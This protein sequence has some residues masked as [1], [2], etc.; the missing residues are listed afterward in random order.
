[1]FCFLQLDGELAER[2][3]GGLLEGAGSL[4]GLLGLGEGEAARLGEL[5]AEVLGHGLGLLGVELLEDVAFL[6]GEDGEDAGDVLTEDAD[7]GDLGSGR[8]GLLGDAELRELGLALLE[9]LEEIFL[10]LGASFGNLEVS[11][12]F[13]FPKKKFFSDVLLFQKKCNYCTYFLLLHPHDILHWIVPLPVKWY[14]LHSH[15][16]CRCRLK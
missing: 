14:T 10:R 16:R 9:V 4:A 13:C 5:G 6:L 8:L 15:R 2:E 11:G 3:L 12:H 7:L 1:V